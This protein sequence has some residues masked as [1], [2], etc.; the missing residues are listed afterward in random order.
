[1]SGLPRHYCIIVHAG[2]GSHHSSKEAQHVQSIQLALYAAQAA[3]ASGA[4]SLGACVAA[5]ACMENDPCCNAGYGSNL[6]E[7]G[8]VE[9][10][11]AVMDGSLPAYDACAAV[12]GVRNPVKLAERLLFRQREQER[13][14]LDRIDPMLLV[15]A[16]ARRWAKRECLET[17]PP[18]ELVSEHA[19]TAWLRYIKLLR[20]EEA[21]ARGGSARSKRQRD[22]ECAEAA[23][24][25]HD[26]H[27][28]VGAVVCVGT[29]VASAVSS[30]GI[31]LKHS[32]RV[33]EAA[34]FG[35]GCW[36][37]DATS[38]ASPSRA[39]V[40]VSVSGVGEAVMTRLLA[41]EVSAALAP[42]D[43]ECAQAT[44]DLLRIESASSPSV[45][46][47]VDRGCGFVALRSVPSD[48]DGDGLPILT[49]WVAAHS[50]PSFALGVMTHA[51]EEPF[52]TVSRRDGGGPRVICASVPAPVPVPV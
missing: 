15:G 18:S 10:D 36:A 9:C 40:G 12:S 52:A 19:R 17:L 44:S 49:E 50:T 26:T 3:L 20:Q 24:G 39:G 21:S 6:T 31:W 48:G 45:K 35:A 2:A 16:G 28:T 37:A 34:C 4:D 5:V 42:P 22:P 25:L 43:V 47:A 29:C 23:N 11:A 14:P 38:H 8:E 27:D 1:M 32:G 30:G 41:R 46:R 51:H 33:G 13:R 7:D